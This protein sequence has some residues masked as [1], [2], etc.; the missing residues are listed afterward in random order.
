MSA[1]SV[2]LAIDL[3]AESGR[4]IVGVLAD[5]V[6]ALHEVHRFAHGPVRLPSGLH[7]EVTGLWRE[8]LAGLAA[9]V[10]WCRRN[11][12]TLRSV[13]VDTWGVDYALVGRSG[14]LLGLPYCYRDGR[15]AAAFRRLM[16]RPG[17]DAIY[18]AT[19]VQPMALN[20]LYQ[21]VAHAEAEPEVV[22]AAEQVLFMPD[23]FHYLL[24]GVRS[25]E[26]TIASTSQ[27][28][29][30]RS[31]RWAEGLLN[32]VGVPRRLLSAPVREGT[33]LGPLSPEVAELVGAG[34]SPIL[35]MVPASHDTACAVA[36]APA[37][38]ESAWCYLSSGTWSLL[39][40]ELEEPCVNAAARDGGFTNEG[41]V[42]GTIRFLKNLTG[43]WLVQEVRRGLARAGQEY[44]YAELSRMACGAAPFRTLIDAQ[45]SEFAQP[46]DMPARIAGHARRSGQPVPETPG[47]LVRCCL[48]SLA[49]SC[50]RALRG[51][52][53]AL[54]RRF[55]VL[56]IVGG[57]VRS[58]LLNQMIADATG[59]TA[60]A[61]PAE[62]TAAGNILVQALGAG[63]VRDRIHIRR[64]AT[65]SFRPTTVAPRDQGDAW[66]RADA[67]L[68]A[69]G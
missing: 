58:E 39:G 49:L 53:R 20:T 7:W 60:V 35:V 16:Q 23:L 30:P 41:G 55:E 21:L 65:G 9:A 40:A 54:E 19:G 22:G 25:N 28:L 4:A 3:G 52:E 11:G 59:L 63:E 44:D 48:E 47:Q 64:I 61:G 31:G 8:V 32:E 5:D 56:H 24:S 14:Q 1:P 2:H 42:G 10:S 6:L 67:R 18:A 13:G 38:G 50:R 15:S 43:L 33:V 69:S 66:D 17:A 36:A 12:L 34:E 27:M 26:A 51:L 68:S 37:D 62:A 45:A 57:G 46:G 29:D